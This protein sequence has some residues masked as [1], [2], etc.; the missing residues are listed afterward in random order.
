MDYL[1]NIKSID[2]IYSA[3][4]NAVLVKMPPRIFSHALL[5][6]LIGIISV[7][8]IGYFVK[9]ERTVS[10]DCFISTD[11]KTQRQKIVFF[12]SSQLDTAAVRKDGYLITG[13]NRS[14]NLQGKVKDMDVQEVYSI[15]GKIADTLSI[16]YLKIYTTT[17]DFEKKFKYILFLNIDSVQ[18]HISIGK[19]EIPLGTARLYKAFSDVR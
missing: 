14:C 4:L 13:E 11:H 1:R 15:N 7:F 8:A 17:S 6:F 5:V 2:Q 3:D 18:K 10:F 12:S 16:E 19:I 9:Y